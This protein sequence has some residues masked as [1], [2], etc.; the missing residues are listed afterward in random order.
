M[1][2]NCSSISTPEKQAALTNYLKQH[3]IHVCLLSEPNLAKGRHLVKL[4]GFNCIQ[5]NRAKQGQRGGG[6]AIILKE[7]INY[8]DL[9]PTD[10]DS[11]EALSIKL[12]QEEESVN[13]TIHIHSTVKCKYY[14]NRIPTHTDEHGSA[15]RSRRLQCP[16][17]N[18]GCDPEPGL[19]G[20]GPTCTSGRMEI[21]PYT[22]TRTKPTRKPLHNQQRNASPCMQQS[23]TA[24]Q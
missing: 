21:Y 8:S 16:W 1:Q 4:N 9:P 18:V 22:T 5:R 17:P 23:H 15:D 6:I 13:V 3:D 19:Q 7:G 11:I 10:L 24:A 20:L 12:T 2:W 14:R